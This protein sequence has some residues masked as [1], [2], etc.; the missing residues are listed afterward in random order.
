MEAVDTAGNRVVG[1]DGTVTFSSSD[2]GTSTVL[3]ANYTCVPA[4]DAGIHVFRLS[5]L[6][7]AGT[8]PREV[9]IEWASPDLGYEGP[10]CRAYVWRLSASGVRRYTLD[11]QWSNSAPGDLR[12]H[13]CSSPMFIRMDI[14]GELIV[15]FDRI[16]VEGLGE[17]VEPVE[18]RT[19]SRQLTAEC[20]DDLVDVRSVVASLGLAPDLTV[21]PRDG[22]EVAPQTTLT[23]LTGEQSWA[24]VVC[25]DDNTLFKLNLSRRVK[26]GVHIG[27]HRAG[28][29]DD[30]WSSAWRGL[31]SRLSG[32]VLVKSGN[33]V[34]KPDNW[35]KHDFNDGLV[36]ARI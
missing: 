4:T 24:G 17:R 8:P 32:V 18:K 9:T 7:R 16:T 3:P 26:G 29:D 28:A 2:V 33:V 5:P 15:E 14:P 11:G 27:L 25:D 13:E 31:P 34:E 22:G 12:P 30:S 1:Y 35:H 20:D 6:P 23:S 10:G 36:W 21:R 19:W